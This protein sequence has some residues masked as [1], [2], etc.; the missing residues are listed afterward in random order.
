M[1]TFTGEFPKYFF[2]SLDLISIA[3]QVFNLMQGFMMTGQVRLG[4]VSL[5]KRRFLTHF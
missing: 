5:G 1:S 2:F 4:L 3:S